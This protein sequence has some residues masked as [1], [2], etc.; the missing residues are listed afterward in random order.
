MRERDRGAQREFVWV[1]HITESDGRIK[2]S[3]VLCFDR[4]DDNVE[5]SIEWVTAQQD[6]RYTDYQSRHRQKS[7]HAA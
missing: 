7:E 1:Y 2:R 3:I 5:G 6:G 4:L